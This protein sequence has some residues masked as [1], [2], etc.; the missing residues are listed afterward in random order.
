M[1]KQTLAAAVVLTTLAVSGSAQAQWSAEYDRQTNEVI[2]ESGFVLTQENIDIS[3]DAPPMGQKGIAW[4]VVEHS[5]GESER[6]RLFTGQG[7]IERIIF[8]GDDDVDV[9][10]NNTSIEMWAFG[11]GGDDF[12]QGGSRGDHLFGENGNDV[13]IGKKG[14]DELNGGEGI[15]DLFGN[16]G[17]DIL[18]P[19]ADFIEGDLVGG[20]GN[21]TAEIFIFTQNSFFNLGGQ[22]GDQIVFL[23][24]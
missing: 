11:G 2:I 10:I 22:A 6:F 21:D 14:D 9:V 16:Q 1:L 15:D 19:G 24:P 5:N 7:M 3:I 23:N 4:L 20:L 17:H 12:L 13:L 8:R 18:T